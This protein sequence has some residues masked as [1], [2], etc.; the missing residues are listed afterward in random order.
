MALQQKAREGKLA[1]A[2][3]KGASC[4][5]TN[6]GSAGGQWFTPVINHPEVAILGIGR[7][8]EKAIVRDGEIVAGSVLGSFSQLRPPYD[9]RSNCAK[10]IK[11]HQAFT[12]R[13]TINF[14]GG[15]MLW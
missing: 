14:N 9:R 2:E 15:V 11:S 4:T 8:A 5:I 3:M 1:P 12:E 7:I 13:S 6:I 10:C